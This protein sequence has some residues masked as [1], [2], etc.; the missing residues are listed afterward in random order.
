MIALLLMLSCLPAAAQTGFPFQSESL[1]YTVKWPGGLSLGDGKMSATK[2]GDGRWD[3][4][5]TL[6]ASI[7]GVIKV[8]DRFRSTI[9]GGECSLEFE[10]ESEH[11]PKKT[12]E[13]VH[14]DQELHIAKRSTQGGGA[15]EFPVP[16]C[17]MD[18]LAFLFHSR[19][20][21]GQGRVPQPR[22]IF[23]GG[24]YEARLEYTGEQT[25]PMQGKSS[26]TDRVAISVTGK[27]SNHTFEV[28][29]ARD[30]ARTPVMIRVPF[31]LGTFTLEL[32]R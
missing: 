4:A 6:D 10:K 13:R 8:T 20:E 12:R 30:A 28:F 27:A 3:L 18:A 29:F 2:E 5:L 11:G 19:R 26:V 22:T 14:F 24:P 15:S 21:L 9:T 1:S 31:P 23:F 17:A 32:V 25:L 16:A 7:E